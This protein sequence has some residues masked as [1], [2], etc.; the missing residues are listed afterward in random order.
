M[1]INQVTDTSSCR[2]AISF[3]KT[4]SHLHRFSV[5]R[6]HTHAHL[7]S[8]CCSSPESA[9]TTPVQDN[10]PAH[11]PLA[12]SVNR[13]RRA[14]ATPFAPRIRWANESPCL[15]ILW[16]GRWWAWGPQ[17]S[18][19]CSLQPVQAPVPDTGL[20]LDL[21]RRPK[22]ATNLPRTCPRLH[23][24][25]KGSFWNPSPYHFC[26]LH[27]STLILERSAH[28]PRKQ[29]PAP[30]STSATFPE[31]DWP[32]FTGTLSG[33]A[34]GAMQP[35]RR[36]TCACRVGCRAQRRLKNSTSTCC[37]HSSRSA[38]IH[39]QSSVGCDW[40]EDDLETV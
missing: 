24:V 20:F 22:L 11:D 19:M 23:L 17:F 32:G 6:T 21:S 15:R 26:C 30:R 5:Q 39:R 8:H 38:K 4:S 31:S 13:L 2:Q 34:T 25:G 3:N 36:T 28:M 33:A 14:E 1:Y 12:A 29:N 7:P 40:C 9:K 27:G 37:E 16:T 18:R 35:L 10:L